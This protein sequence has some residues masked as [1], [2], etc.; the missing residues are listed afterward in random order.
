MIEAGEKWTPPAGWPVI[1]RDQVKA[2]L[3]APGMP[4]EM[5][6]AEIEGVPTRVWKNALPNL[7]VLA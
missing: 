6:T 1:T 7:A 5:E 2:A 4:F 3:C